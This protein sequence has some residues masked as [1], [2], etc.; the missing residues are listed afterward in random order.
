MSVT[1]SNGDPPLALSA[2]DPTNGLYEG[3]WTPRRA[4][5]QVTILARASAPGFPSSATVQI[6]GQVAP[7]TVPVLAPN[8]TLDVF[9][10][11]VGAG[12]GPGNIVQIYG[13]GLAAQNPVRRQYVA[14]AYPGLNGTDR[15]HRR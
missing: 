11:Q 1:F 3:T 5:S 6:A 2:V 12:L 10:P 14:A 7:N 4:S 13:T 8:G 9:H 15:D